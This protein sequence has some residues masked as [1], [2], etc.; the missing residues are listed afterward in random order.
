MCS[1]V[2]DARLSPAISF[3]RAPSSSVTATVVI[4]RP[5]V[6]GG[7]V[8]PVGRIPFQELPSSLEVASKG[9]GRRSSKPILGIYEAI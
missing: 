8:T 3:A 4:A 6:G 1:F 9:L 2:L 7:R 5:G